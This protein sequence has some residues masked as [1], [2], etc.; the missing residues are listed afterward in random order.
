MIK[1]RQKILIAIKLGRIK[2]KIDN[3]W[4]LPFSLYMYQIKKIHLSI[5]IWYKMIEISL[6][7]LNIIF[8]IFEECDE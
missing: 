4:I 1:V 6:F 7:K 5:K 2:I 8:C 3:S